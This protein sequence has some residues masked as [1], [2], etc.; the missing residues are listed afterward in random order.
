MELISMNKDLAA[1]YSYLDQIRMNQ[2]A[3][4]CRSTLT[5][6]FNKDIKRAVALLN[7]R[8]LMFPCLYILQESIIRH[9]MQ[10]YLNVRNLTALRITGQIKD[11]KASETDYLSSKQNSTHSVLKWI[12][13]T[14]SA[15]KI[16]EDDYEEILDVAVSVL[17]NTYNDMDILPL[18]VDLVFTRNR[19]ASHIHDL[20]WAL[21]RIHDPQVLKLIA[22]YLRSSD[23]KDAELAAELLNL[24]STDI[25]GLNGDN[26]RQYQGYLHW[27]EENQPYLYFTQESFQ[28]SSMPSF[29]NLDLERKYLQKG[30]SSY[31]KQPLSSLE[32]KERECIAAFKQLS[33]DKQKLLSECSQKICSKSVP[34]WKAWLSEPVEEQVASAK[35]R[36]EGEE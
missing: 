23:P 21:F 2:G 35:A 30:T 8:R 6:I 3:D 18:A 26:E 19:N 11:P 7:D 13:E 1:E 14:G 16:H 32:E 20:V 33:L 5:T 22:Q 25:Q 4:R 10:K 34:T 31:D 27:L 36:L 28:Y 15:E 29:C 17:I 12:V 9:Q 24:D